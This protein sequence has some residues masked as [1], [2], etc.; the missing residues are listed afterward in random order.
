MTI[1]RLDPPGFRSEYPTVSVVIVNLNG[2][3]MLGPCLESIEKQTYDPEMVE[4]IL[5]DNAS[6]DGSVAMVREHFP[7]VR[8]LVNDKNVG[9]SPAVNQAARVANGE[10]LALSG[11]TCGTGTGGV[12]RW[13]SPRRT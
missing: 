12:G 11:R 9:F 10:I 6:T 4:V 3:D 1:T 13:G 8:V 7:R 5:I 2:K